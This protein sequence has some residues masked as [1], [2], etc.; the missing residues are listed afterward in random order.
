MSFYFYAPS[1]WCVVDDV[2]PD[3]LSAE[4]AEECT[5]KTQKKQTQ[6]Y[7]FTFLIVPADRVG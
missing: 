2:C 3:F 7:L 4:N 1:N 6:R 5:Q